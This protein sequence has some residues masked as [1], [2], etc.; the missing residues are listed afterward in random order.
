MWEQK[1]MD[2]I[3]KMENE[4]TNVIIASLKYIKIIFIYY[5][6]YWNRYFNIP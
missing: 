4:N 1:I 3:S 2:N 5:E 6:V